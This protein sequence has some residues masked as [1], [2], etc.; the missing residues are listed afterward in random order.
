[1]FR[2]K[3][4]S[5]LNR[6]CSLTENSAFFIVSILFVL[7]FLMSFCQPPQLRG[8]SGMI[9]VCDNIVFPVEA[10][11][12]VIFPFQHLVHSVLFVHIPESLSFFRLLFLLIPV[13]LVLS[14]GFF[15]DSPFIGFLSAAGIIF[16]EHSINTDVE[17]LLILISVLSVINIYI[18]PLIAGRKRDLLLGLALGMCTQAKGICLPFVLIV[19]ILEL[20]KCKD[21]I[22]RNLLNRKYL[23]LPFVISGFLWSGIVYMQSGEITF[24]TESQQRSE[25]IIITG[26]HGYI[27][28]AEGDQTYIRRAFG[29]ND[30]ES[31]ISVAL[32]TILKNP[33]RYF[34]SIPLRGGYV[35]GSM[36]VFALL[37]LFY[38]F[39]V[40]FLWKENKLR[41]IL[42]SFVYFMAG[43]LLL[44]VEAR[45]FIPA[46]GLLIFLS[47]CF[48]SYVLFR[49]LPYCNLTAV[50]I[51]NDNSF[52][53]KTGTVFM[54]A[55][56][57]F[58]LFMWLLSLFLLAVFPWRH[59]NADVQKWLAHHPDN[60]YLLRYSPF[61]SF[62]DRD[63]IKKFLYGYKNADRGTG[64]EW[65]KNYLL[66][67]AGD[68]NSVIARLNSY[69]GSGWHDL[70]LLSADDFRKG[71]IVRGTE[72]AEGALVSCMIANGYVRN[73]VALE[74]E[75][76]KQTVNSLRISNAT[77][78]SAAFE[79]F[80]LFMPYEDASLQKTILDSPA[81]EFLNPEK[82]ILKYITLVSESCR[83]NNC[84][85]LRENA[86]PDSVLKEFKG[87]SSDIERE[88]I[89]AFYERS[90]VP[91][92]L[93]VKVTD[94]NKDKILSLCDLFLSLITDKEEKEAWRH[95][96]AVRSYN[97]FYY[98]P[99]VLYTK[100]HIHMMRGEKEKATVAL[101]MAVEYGNEEFLKT[102][103]V[104]V[105]L[106]SLEGAFE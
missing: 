99:Y 103:D 13:F 102:T 105:L 78:C 62:S 67:F 68:L 77:F 100:A 87:I 28:T 85:L 45:Y 34:K 40:F 65:I 96:V 81:A 75:E 83:K 27:S 41:L 32:K 1:M 4:I 55:G 101:K 97:Y 59:A 49:K 10:L 22:F 2:K 48:L 26:A 37:V 90:L 89:P 15:L 57:A 35:C 11:K 42:L 84:S 36:T 92:C 63:D 38:I 9:P 30:N 5:I 7:I 52:F 6:F 82:L 21:S 29:V 91:L 64:V 8:L 86:V 56:I 50:Q 66:Y 39:I 71:N 73:S 80:L 24:F 61:S 94:K 79:K 69:S 44:P 76:R 16:L 72:R 51:N 25:G 98:R 17:Q 14:A 46:W 88:L 12:T 106:K 104:S 70:L 58:P 74:I 20:R 95:G 31:V 47:A 54:S 23:L 19:F 93:N 18:C 60:I 53:Y 33:L 3:I 43:G